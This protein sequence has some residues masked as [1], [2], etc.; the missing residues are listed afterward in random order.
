MMTAMFAM[1]LS[2]NLTAGSLEISYAVEDAAYQAVTKMSEDPRVA[3]E[4]KRLAFVKLWQSTSNGEAL[5]NAHM[6]VAVFESA[7]GTVPTGFQIVLHSNRAEQWALIDNVFDDAVDF[8][9]YN[10]A[11]H[12]ELNKLE[13]CD[14]LLLAK[15][16]GVRDGGSDGL[17]TVRLALKIIQVKTARQIWSGVVEG[18]YNAA[19]RPDNEQLPYFVRKAI[20]EAAEDAASKIPDSLD[21][22]GVLVVPLEGPGGRAMTQAFMSALTAAGKQ[23][24]IRLYDLPSGNIADRMLGRHLWALTGSGKTLTPSV[25]KQIEERTK[26]NGKLAVLTGSVV[27]GRVMPETWVDPTGAPV[28]RLTGSYSDVRKNPTHF[29]IVADLKVRDIQDAFRVVASVSATGV[30]KR[31][32]T[33]D[34]VEQARSLFTVRNIVVVIVILIILWF[35]GRFMFRVR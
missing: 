19:E 33:E 2:Q 1:V 7:L 11:T 35:V 6:D 24:K 3:S 25:I 28:D 27:A 22:Y 23:N 18:R 26:T 32:V 16:V 17:S 8:E 20:E 30:Y 4:V 12:P 13:L 14:S 5:S 15:V 10:P 29:E 31:D 9:S 21:G 34:V